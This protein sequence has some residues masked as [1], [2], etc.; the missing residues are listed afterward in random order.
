MN[1]DGHCLLAYKCLSLLLCK[2]LS[3]LLPSSL[4]LDGTDLLPD[5]VGEVVLELAYVQ[6]VYLVYQV[7][8]P[9]VQLFHLS[10]R[11]PLQLG[12]LLGLVLD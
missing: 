8:Q 4:F 7:Q 12:K 1:L 3:G 6:L 10:F 9:Y 5:H 11:A 2:S